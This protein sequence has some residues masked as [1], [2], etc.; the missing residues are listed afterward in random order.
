MKKLALNML[1]INVLLLLQYGCTSNQL[2]PTDP[3][4]RITALA[5]ESLPQ[6]KEIDKKGA[7][8]VGSKDIQ[9]IQELLREKLAI[10]K[11]TEDKLKKIVD[12]EYNKEILFE[13]EGN[14]DK[15]V[16]KKITFKNASLQ[17]SEITINLQA[18]IETIADLSSNVEGI[19]VDTNG[20]EI[21]KEKFFPEEEKSHGIKAGEHVTLYCNL[22]ASNVSNFSKIIVR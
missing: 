14:K 20:I 7:K 15:F 16:I 1:V 5:E 9:T 4:N 19:I 21:H 11:L 10:E 8:T 22:S 18:E 13:Q 17:D 6:I 2:P 3:L 12:N